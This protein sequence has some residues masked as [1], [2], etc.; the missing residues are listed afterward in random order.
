MGKI[1]QQVKLNATTL[2]KVNQSNME[3]VHFKTQFVGVYQNQKAEEMKVTQLVVQLYQ[4][5]ILFNKMQQE[6]Q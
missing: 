4:L 6:H 5:T 2:E 3:S 1:V